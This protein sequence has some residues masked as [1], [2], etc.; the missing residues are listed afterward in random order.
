MAVEEKKKIVGG[1]VN[2]KPASQLKEQKRED[3]AW[4]NKLF[5]YLE[6][7]KKSFES[8]TS[9]K[10]VKGEGLFG[11]L[12]GGLKGLFGGGLSGL[13][14]KI[15]GMIGLTGIFTKVAGLGLGAAILPAAIILWGLTSVFKIV[16]KW[17]EGF[18]VDGFAG[19]FSSALGNKAEGGAMSALG[20]ALTWAGIGAT[21]GM[22]FGPLGMLVG[23]LIGAAIG[24]FFGWLGSDK[25]KKGIKSVQ[26][27]FGFPDLMTEDEK[28]AHQKKIDDIAVK[29]KALKS[30]VI[31]A[32]EAEIQVYTDMQAKGKELTLKEMI[33]LDKLYQQKLEAEQAIIDGQKEMATLQRDL[34]RQKLAK[35]TEK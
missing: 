17:S 12:F 4:K 2:K 34:E 1:L 16:Q 28:V 27:F 25:I 11:K 33:A 31:P 7:Y 23:G 5:G 21:A 19:G 8:L 3:N 6:G 26:D 24:G 30:E 22:A 14:T 15:L 13:M 32:I 29:I 18:K 10:K 9:G 20:G 35:S